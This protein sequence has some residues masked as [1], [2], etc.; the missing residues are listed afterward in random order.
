MSD[1]IGDL[2]STM[3]W[4]GVSLALMVAG[5]VVVDL[6]TPGKLREQV[7]SSINAALLVGAKLF[8]VGIIVSSAVWTAVDD[9]SE[10]LVDAVLYS[11]LGLAVSAVS[12]LVLDWVMPARMRHLVNE[13]AFDPVSVVAV[14]SELSVALVIAAAIS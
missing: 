13:P 6:M 11:V 4:V 7:S 3:S 9:L 12:F 5:F 8:A 14:G 2:G 10:G 1:F